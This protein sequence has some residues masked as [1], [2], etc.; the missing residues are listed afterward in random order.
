MLL[1]SSPQLPA[2]L[3]IQAASL[4]AGK[5]LL[6]EGAQGAPSSLGNQPEL[7]SQPGH[8]LGRSHTPPAPAEAPRART[9]R[10][11][12]VRDGGYQEML[13]GGFAD[14]I[15]SCWSS[16]ATPGLPQA[17]GCQC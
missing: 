15:C 16:W 4:P 17:G 13:W 8:L 14:G 3:L 11:G 7:S 9:W 1:P 6:Q 5:L 12:H 2:T 10:G